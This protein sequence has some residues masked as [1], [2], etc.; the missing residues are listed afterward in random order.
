MKL[1]NLKVIGIDQNTPIDIR[2]K[3]AFNKNN[4]NDA[5]KQIIQI[6]GGDEASIDEV[7]ILSTCNRTEI[8][9]YA[10]SG[11]IDLSFFLC[12]YFD[13]D[14]G[15]IERYV[16][17][18]SGIDAIRHLFRVA[19]GLESMVVGEEQILGQ[20]K[21]AYERAQGAGT[22]HKV[23][24][25]LFLDG[26][27]LGKNVRTTT[28]IA[29]IP[30]SVSYIAVK[31]IE[32]TFEGKISDKSVF[33]IGAGEMGKIVIKN[34]IAKGVQRIYVTNR[35]HKRTVDLM[36]EFP[37]VIAVNYEDKYNAM[38]NCD[39]VVSATDAPH[40]TV[41]Y[42][43]F[44]EV[45]KG[46]RIC[47]IDIAL[48]RDIDPR[49]AELPG[50]SLYTIDDLKWVSHENNLKRREFIKDIEQMVDEAVERY[51]RWFKQQELVPAI[52][53]IDEFAKKVCEAEYNRLKNKVS[54]SE[55]DMERIKI[56]LHRVAS[57]M[58]NRHIKYIKEHGGV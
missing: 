11:E 30:L 22:V 7:V 13:V 45:Y 37:Q 12:R 49:I 51:V 52:K 42:D 56:A 34:L 36:L 48:P 38:A 20:V 21:D 5:L 57:K 6:K 58:V 29:D 4:I 41:N 3:V 14:P 17:R 32:E 46:N 28:G 55:D 33:V 35:T 39:I 31:F 1:S 27:A 44:K 9:T 16:Y 10:E 18:Y 47:M 24:S 43:K 40:Y 2:E 54:L 19:C 8:Y 25:R 23:L 26:I 53:E 15:Y 50:V